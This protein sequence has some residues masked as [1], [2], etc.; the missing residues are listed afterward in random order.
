MSDEPDDTTIGR[1]GWALVVAS[2]VVAFVVL[3]FPLHYHLFPSLVFALAIALIVLLILYRLAVEVNR[4][5]DAETE[6][7]VRKIVPASSVAEGTTRVGGLEGAQPSIAVAVPVRPDASA[8][9]PQRPAAVVT[10]LSRVEPA[11]IIPP[12]G[13]AAPSVP[14]APPK[15]AEEPQPFDTFANLP[16]DIWARP[17]PTPEPSP[18]PA[19]SPAMA[20]ASAPA[21]AAEP[22]AGFRTKADLAAAAAEAGAAKPKAAAK[23]APKPKAE[24]KPKAD[25]KPKAEARPKAAEKAPAKAPAKARTAKPKAAKAAPAG[26]ERL[27]APRGGVADD[28][29]EIEGIGPAIEK[30]VNGLGFYHFDQIAAWTDEDVARV[31]AELRTFKGRIVRDKWVEQ[32]RII[33]TEGLEAFR[34]RAKTNDY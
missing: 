23:S 20:P 15:A 24:P 3:R 18:E 34:E 1:G 12:H 7:Q 2:G 9:V 30:L 28:L 27:S 14:P 33:V 5:D 21:A 4:H 25:P 10:P 32:A 29:K 19:P 26:L 13:V 31:D 16:D 22:K 17:A 8:P 6:R 11:P